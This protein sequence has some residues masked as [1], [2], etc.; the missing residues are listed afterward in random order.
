M[1]KSISKLLLLQLLMFVFMLSSCKKDDSV[2]S[3]WVA[4]Y[5]NIILGDQNNHINGH[6]LKTQTGQT[7]AVDTALA[8]QKSLAMLF[9]TESGG[10]N[11]FFTF[12]A[13]GTAAST[14]G[15]SANRLFTNSPGGINYWNQAYLNSGM[16][17]DGVS[18]TSVEF[19]A[20]VSQKDWS[21]FDEVFKTK[22]NGLADLSFKLH[23]TLNPTAGDVYLVQFNGLVRAIICIR[24]LVTSGA[25]GGNIRFDMILEGKDIYMNNSNANLIQPLKK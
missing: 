1:K 20:L 25:S 6:F 16:I 5:S 10:A 8:H 15:T 18:M 14:F 13:D 19:D 3:T 11:S 4:T 22:N 17:A 7:I 21:K 12:P 9:F 24:S 23:Y 2:P